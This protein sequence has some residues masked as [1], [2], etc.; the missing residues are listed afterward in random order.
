[1]A[2]PGLLDHDAIVVEQVRKLFELRNQYGLFD[3][4]GQRIG[5]IEQVEQSPL[6]FLTR[7]FSDLDVMLPTT[8][9]VEDQSGQPVLRLHK[10]WFRWKVVVSRSDG[11]V[12]GTIAKQARV[13]KAR[14]TLDGPDGMRLGEV[15]AENWRARHFTVLDGSG[16]KVA[17]VTKKWRGLVAEALTDADTYVV[18]LG[19]STQ[20][21]RS[22]AL[23]AALSIDVIMKQKDT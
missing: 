22:L 8:L 11:T 15:R 14:F 18:D 20:P 19:G 12:L 1:M 13:G 7:L 2:E 6:Q 5:A 21:L 3:T 23:A 9:A 17:E 16:Q 10:P 4:A